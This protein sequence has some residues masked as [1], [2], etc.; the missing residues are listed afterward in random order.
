MLAERA[1][2][3]SAWFTAVVGIISRD[4]TAK[5]NMI[6]L[7]HSKLYSPDH[8]VIQTIV[9][10]FGIDLKKLYLKHKPNLDA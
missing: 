9:N 8:Y 4:L 2:F 3:R 5:Y 6:K 10:K 7:S 1:F